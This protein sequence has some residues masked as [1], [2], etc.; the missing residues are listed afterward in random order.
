MP[1]NIIMRNGSS[2]TLTGGGINWAWY[3]DV[4]IVWPHGHPTVTITR[5]YRLHKDRHHPHPDTVGTFC[6]MENTK[7]Q[8]CAVK[9]VILDREW[10]LPIENIK[11][12]FDYTG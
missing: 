11:H 3:L 4:T 9:A 10:I 7:R 8:A 6:I 12:V 1:N 2:F 5:H